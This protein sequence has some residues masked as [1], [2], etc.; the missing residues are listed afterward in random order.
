M[1]DMGH[2][3]SVLHRKDYGQAGF[4]PW[5]CHS[6]LCDL[7]LGLLALSFSFAICQGVHLSRGTFYEY[8]EGENEMT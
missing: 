4:E 3:S 7:A 6:L 1:V 5:L 2:S 8:G